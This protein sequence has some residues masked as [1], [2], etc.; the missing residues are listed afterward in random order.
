MFN[1]LSFSSERCNTQ[2]D[3]FQAW[4]RSM[5]MRKLRLTVVE[6]G[7]GSAIPTVRRLGNRIA[8][9]SGATLVRINPRESE[10][11]TGCVNIPLGAVEALQSIDALL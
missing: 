8:V 2:E 1:D 3:H 9:N 6:I 5:E 10:D 4:V 11:T 7:A